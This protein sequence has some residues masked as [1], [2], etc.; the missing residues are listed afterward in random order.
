MREAICIHIGQAW[1][2]Q[3][4]TVAFGTERDCHNTT[5]KAAQSVTQ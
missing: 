1:M 5:Q 4:V 2:R 3:R